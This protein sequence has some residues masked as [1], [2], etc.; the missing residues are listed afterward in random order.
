KL[1]DPEILRQFESRY[2]KIGIPALLLQIATGLRLVYNYTDNLFD[3]FDFG[4]S[5]HTFIALKIILLLV[6]VVIAAHARIRLIGKLKEESMAFL[7]AHII[8]IT[9]IGIAILFF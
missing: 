6:T 1:H 7:A 4:Y 9:I 8:T 2:E 3:V 5:Q